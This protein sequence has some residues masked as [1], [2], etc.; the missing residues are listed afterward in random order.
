MIEIFLALILGV[1]FAFLFV[2]EWKRYRK[3]HE[4]LVEQTRYYRDA[5][6]FFRVKLYG[7]NEL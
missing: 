2:L 4:M 6:N 7:G 5:C 1:V 3:Y